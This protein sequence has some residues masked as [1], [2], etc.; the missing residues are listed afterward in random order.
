MVSQVWRGPKFLGYPPG[1]LPTETYCHDAMA[2][3]LRSLV[4]VLKEIRAGRFRPDM[5][6]SGVLQGPLLARQEE[7]DDVSLWG[8]GL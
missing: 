7:R 6:C 3:P 5:T 4:R 2:A 1:V 8:L